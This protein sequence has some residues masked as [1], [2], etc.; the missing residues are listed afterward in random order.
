MQRTRSNRRIILKILPFVI[1]FLLV[2]FDQLTKLHFRNLHNSGNFTETVVIKDFFYFRYTFNSGAAWGFL[3]DKPWAQIF[4]KVLTGFALA[5]FF[6]ILIFSF[7]KKARF[8]TY[9]MVL[10]IGGTIGNF[11]DRLAFNGVSDFISLVFGKYNFPIFNLA[12][13]FL[14]VG[15]FVTILYLLFIGEGALFKRAS[16]KNADKNNKV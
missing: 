13:V 9:G 12:D 11:I 15:A 16:R 14:C 5:V 3:A 6:V 4:F 1:L 8:L 7:K 2:L 10:V